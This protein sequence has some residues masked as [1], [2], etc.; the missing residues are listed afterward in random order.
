MQDVM[1]TL[2][3]MVPAAS[4]PRDVSRWW[5]LL[6]VL[7]TVLLVTVQCVTGQRSVVGVNAYIDFTTK[8]DGDPPSHLDTGQSVDFTLQN[9]PHRKPRISGGGLLPQMSLPS[10]G[11]YADYYQATADGDCRA[12]GTRFTVN[13]GDGST[14]ESIM[15]LAIW[16]GV[17]KGAGTIVP[18]SPAHIGISTT[19]G[20]WQWWVN[21]AL[22][23]GHLRSV[24]SGT[25]APPASDGKASWEVAVFIDPDR[26]VG[27]L[28]LPGVDAVTGTR[29]VTLDESEINA[30]LTAAELPKVSLSQLLS[31]SN[32][33]MVEHFA[34]RTPIT[35][36]YPRF[37]SMWANCSRNGVVP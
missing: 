9:S 18:K 35:A 31:G 7:I 23:K 1:V 26:G 20:E 32:V 27:H 25:F 11:T 22:A 34:S 14:T 29:W 12:A 37:Q 5:K 30:S 3:S 13:S 17:Y 2:R 28:Y 15:T 8:A 33:V 4:H 36:R 24:K 16:A 21:D 19:D 10:S 6:A